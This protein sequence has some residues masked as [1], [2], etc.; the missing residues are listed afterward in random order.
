MAKNYSSDPNNRPK[1]AKPSKPQRPSDSAQNRNRP[2]KPV[3]NEVRNRSQE[4]S[5]SSNLEKAE[6]LE[7]QIAY[8]ELSN[9][10]HA[11]YQKPITKADRR[12]QMLALSIE[13]VVVIM[14]GLLGAKFLFPQSVGNLSNESNLET[15]NLNP[16]DRGDDVFTDNNFDNSNDVAVAQDSNLSLNCQDFAVKKAA[17]YVL[18][19]NPSDPFGLDRDKNNLACERLP[20][21]DRPNKE[22]LNCDDFIA[23]KAAQHVLEL[24]P[25]DP[26]G[27]DRDGN[28]LACESL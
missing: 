15:G 9:Q 19:S 25:S 26:F 12:N 14:V 28:K 16:S 6:N 5:L 7:P 23:Q 20:E 21:G 18:N 27:L 8:Q 10:G 24:D 13:I 3:K 2:E 4:S 22:D 11:V 1:P 17:Q